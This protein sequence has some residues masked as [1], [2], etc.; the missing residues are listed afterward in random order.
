MSARDRRYLR[1]LSLSSVHGSVEEAKVKEV[2][3][4]NLTS[5]RDGWSESESYVSRT[6]IGDL[7][8]TRRC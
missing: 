6:T 1:S 8:E 5:R 3:R 4:D 2:D 7:R